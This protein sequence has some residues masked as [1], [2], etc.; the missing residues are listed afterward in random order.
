MVNRC[1]ALVQ[2]RVAALKQM[3]AEKV[4]QLLG[5]ER[6]R[7]LDLKAIN[8][9][10]RQEEIEILE[11][12]IASSLQHIERASLQLQGVKLIVAS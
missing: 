1:E 7:L 5:A 12:L 6:Q 11:Q 4:E 3:A 10:I 2:S 8:P 9:N